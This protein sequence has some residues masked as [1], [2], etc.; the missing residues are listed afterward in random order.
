MGGLTVQNFTTE[1]VYVRLGT[2][3]MTEPQGWLA[4]LLWRWG[5]M[6]R[7]GY[8]VKLAAGSIFDMPDWN[9]GVEVIAVGN[10]NRVIQV[11]E[12]A[13]QGT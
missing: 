3:T 8:T 13:R 6:R 4:R 12:G 11:A 2:I 7:P 1:V 9:G 10:C 5:W